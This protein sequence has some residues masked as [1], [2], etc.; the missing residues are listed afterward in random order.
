MGWKERPYRVKRGIIFFAI[1]ALIFVYAIFSGV[2]A[3]FIPEETPKIWPLGKVAGRIT[4]ILI[5]LA[6]IILLI[7]QIHGDPGAILN[8]LGYTLI[9]IY[10][11]AIGALIGWIYG[12]IKNTK[13][14]NTERTYFNRKIT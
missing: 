5:P 10:L 14:L 6:P 3:S 9:I 13:E 7:S 8:I 2:W 1:F 4:F 12:K 11:F